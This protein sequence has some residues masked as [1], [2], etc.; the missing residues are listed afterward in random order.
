MK[1]TRKHLRRIIQEERAEIH[2]E[3]LEGHRPSKYNAMSDAGY[4]MA[5]RA[6]RMFNKQ[7]PDI[8]VGLDSR[9]GW[10]TVNGKKAVN[11]SQASGSPLSMEDVVD[12]MKQAYLGHTTNETKKLTA[13]KIHEIIRRAEALLN[14]EPS[15]YYK[16][17]KKGTIT[18]AEYEE[19]VSRFNS[20]EKLDPDLLKGAYVSSKEDR[21]AM[22]GYIANLKTK[23][24]WTGSSEELESRVHK[25]LIDIGFYLESHNGRVNPF[26]KG[27]HPDGGYTSAIPGVIKDAI[28]SGE[29]D[30][31][32][33]EEIQ[34]TY[35]K[36]D[37]SID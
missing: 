5:R 35:R 25:Y 23:K 9:N 10:I 27:S 22:K 11:M 32:T 6:K 33:W 34:P 7:Y 26:S 18:K 20:G 31:A 29:I 14:E 4:S 21:E 15:D 24:K 19:L 3:S 2:K 28:A 13:I 12:K 8:K 17:Y 16:D 1:I 37:R 36:I 30:W